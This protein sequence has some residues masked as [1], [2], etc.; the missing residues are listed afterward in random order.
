MNTSGMEIERKF[1]IRYPDKAFL[2]SAYS[3]TEIVQTYLS[4]PKGVS[5]R[6]RKRWDAEQ[7]K[8]YHTEKIHISDMTRIEKE[9]EIGEAEYLELLTRADSERKPIEKMRCCIDY[10]GQ[11]FEIDLYPFYTDRAIMEIE[12]ASETQEIVFPPEVEIIREVTSDK[13]YTNASMA[14]S[15]PYDEI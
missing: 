6:V 4:A 10:R 14:R 13:R 3:T 11:I 1:L 9:R 2:E 15:I 7:C 5:E 12:L 8:Y